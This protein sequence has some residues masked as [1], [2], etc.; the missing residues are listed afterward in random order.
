MCERGG[1]GVFAVETRDPDVGDDGG[2][3]TKG[4]KWRGGQRRR[5]GFA[6]RSPYRPA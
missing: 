5:D 6:G 1:G 2:T 4:M 3:A